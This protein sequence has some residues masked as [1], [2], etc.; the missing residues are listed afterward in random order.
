ML[1]ICR[2]IDRV[3]NLPADTVPNAETP[4]LT[5]E[6]VVNGMKETPAL[7]VKRFHQPPCFG[8]LGVT[9]SS[10][11]LSSSPSPL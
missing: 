9:H 10:T 6:D 1:S 2:I 4:I 5:D 7:M 11:K 8:E 3:L